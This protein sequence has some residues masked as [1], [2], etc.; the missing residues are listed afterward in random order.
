[1]NL[2]VKGLFHNPIEFDGIRNLLETDKYGRFATINC[3]N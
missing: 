3:A 2:S 1:M